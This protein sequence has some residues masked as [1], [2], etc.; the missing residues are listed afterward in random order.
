MAV[1]R[2]MFILEYSIKL[3]MKHI[4]LS[5]LLLCAAQ[6]LRASSDIDSARK[7]RYDSIAQTKRLYWLTGGVGGEGNGIGIIAKAN[8]AI[9]V[10]SF[11]AKFLIVRGLF[12]SWEMNEYGLYYGRQFYV[13][14]LI[15]RI[16]A[17]V[18]YLNGKLVKYSVEE[19]IRTL[20]LGAEIELILQGEV[21]G[22]GISIFGHLA[23]SLIIGGLSLNVHLGKLD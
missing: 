9:G 22:L 17:G 4:I 13:D 7:F 1:L 12:T 16:A 10:E 15:G 14:V 20:A 8:V 18:S 6:S 23:P 11:I 19:R 2:S 21:A 3:N 5:I